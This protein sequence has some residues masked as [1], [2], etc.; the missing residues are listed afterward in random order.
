VP[1]FLTVLRLCAA[2]TAQETDYNDI[3]KDSGVSAVTVKEWINILE[4]A[5]LV[6][7][8]RPFFSNLSKRLIKR[9]KLF[10]LD[11]GLAARLQGWSEMLPLLSSPQIG[12]CLKH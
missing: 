9:P 1:E 6:Y 5:D 4:H 10:F 2:R 12:G 8:L 3:H 11:T 7:Q